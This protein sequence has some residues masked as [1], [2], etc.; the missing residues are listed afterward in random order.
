MRQKRSNLRQAIK[1][2]LTGIILLTLASI[3]FAQISSNYDLS[4]HV[5]GGGIGQMESTGHSLQGTLGQTAA[6]SMVSDG[7]TLCNGFWCEGAEEYMVYL[8]LV[9]RNSP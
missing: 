2:I 5:I 9:L 8:P 1:A 6:G 4:W 7:H 3:A